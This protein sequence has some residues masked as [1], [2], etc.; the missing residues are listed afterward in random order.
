LGIDFYKNSPSN[1]KA[2]KLKLGLV[3]FDI[4]LKI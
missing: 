4:Y 3:I 1:N 2:K